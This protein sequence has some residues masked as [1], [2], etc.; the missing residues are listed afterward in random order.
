L[1]RYRTTFKLEKEMEKVHDEEER[2]N[3]LDGK[4]RTSCGF[5]IVEYQAAGKTE[6]QR[7]GV[8]VA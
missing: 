1:H 4:A 6:T 8:A 2:R 7:N 5:Y 3:R